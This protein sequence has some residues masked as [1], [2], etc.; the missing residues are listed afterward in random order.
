MKFHIIT[1]LVFFNFH[2]FKTVVGSAVFVEYQQAHKKDH[3]DKNKI[4][5]FY[6][7]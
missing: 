5:K 7:T 3:R 6:F 2:F 4:K 1:V